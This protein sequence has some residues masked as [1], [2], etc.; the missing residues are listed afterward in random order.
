MNKFNRIILRLML[1]LV[2]GIVLVAC[3]NK[4]RA[5]YSSDDLDR[6]ETKVKNSFKDD[7]NYSSKDTSE[8]I[9]YIHEHLDDIE[10]KDEAKK[11]YEKASYIEN[12]SKQSSQNI[13]NTITKYASRAKQYA[14][15]VYLANDDEVNEVINKNK[16][17]FDN[18][19]STFENS[20]DDLIDEFS[21]FFKKSDSN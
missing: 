12:V 4:A 19:R 13:D 21:N 18:Y 2:I 5:T 14:H 11:I 6:I 16:D 15:D 3:Q 20:K 17:A 10:D 7:F 8:A 9:T 1:I